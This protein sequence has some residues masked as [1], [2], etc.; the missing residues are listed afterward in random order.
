MIP[1]LLTCAALVGAVL[2][3]CGDDAAPTTTSVAP[4]GSGAAPGVDTRGNSEFCTALD[5]R[6][7]AT[8]KL[9]ELEGGDPGVE[10]ALG[11]MRS[12]VAKASDTAPADLRDD[13]A[14]LAAGVET[15]YEILVRAGFDPAKAT[16]ADKVTI[17]A[18]TSD[19]TYANA[20][21]AIE[22]YRSANCAAL[23]PAGS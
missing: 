1:R 6:D 11:E 3:G 10:A 9:N 12:A 20:D 14:K 19:T 5:E 17:G 23:A 15:M 18:L 7:V 22:S 4:S 2:G 8:K 21:Q 13:A 16:D